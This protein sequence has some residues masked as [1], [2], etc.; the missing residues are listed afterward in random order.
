MGILTALTD[1]PAHLTFYFFFINSLALIL[2]IV[3]FYRTLPYKYAVLSSAFLA[4]F[5]AFTIYSNN[6]WAQCLLPLIIILFNISLYRLIKYEFWQN[7]FYMSLLAVLAA[8]LHGSG[9]MLFPLLVIIAIAYWKKIDKR[10]ILL[11]F[12]ATVLLFI[13]YLIYLSNDIGLPKLMAYHASQK[14]D[15]HWKI[16]TFHVRMA[17]FDFF[18]GYFRYDFNEILRVIARGWRFILYPLTFIPSLFFIIGFE[19]EYLITPKAF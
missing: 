17:S 18:R 5:P 3:Y 8:Q 16:L 10:M 7:F 13:P 11:A 1:D 2:A 12:L 15:F 4:L 9:F 14:Q 19:E 6:I